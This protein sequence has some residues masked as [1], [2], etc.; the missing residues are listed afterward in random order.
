MAA[1]I[2]GGPPGVEPVA[3][4]DRQ[5]A[6]VVE[7]A[8]AHPLAGGFIA[9]QDV[10]R[11]AVTIIGIGS[12]P[13]AQLL[14]DQF[15]VFLFAGEKSPAR[16]GMVFFRESLQL[17][18][19]VVLRINADG[20][21]KDILA[22]AVAQ[23]LLYLGQARGFQRADVETMGVEEL[24]GH[25]LAFEQI[26]IELDLLAVLGGQRDVGKVVGS[27]VSVGTR[28]K[29]PGEGGDPYERRCGDQCPTFPFHG[30]TPYFLVCRSGSDG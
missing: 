20:I 17:F 27:P 25:D 15:D 4:Q 24:N 28:G 8:V 1:V 11:M 21:K 14:A 22:H 7:S 3:D 5:E 16:A 30:V 23:H 10:G 13:Q 9:D 19:R 18:R 29:N 12:F 2:L 26:V 6:R